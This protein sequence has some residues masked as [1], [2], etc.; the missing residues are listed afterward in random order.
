MHLWWFT[1]LYLLACVGD[2]VLCCLCDVF[3]STDY[4]NVR[5][6]CYVGLNWLKGVLLQQSSA[7]VLHS[8]WLGSE[9]YFVFLVGMPS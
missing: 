6:L 7:S 2:L 4:T 9:L 1:Y 5:Q 8:R 3:L